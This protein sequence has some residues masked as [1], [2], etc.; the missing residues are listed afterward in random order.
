MVT[1]KLNLS[2]PSDLLTIP[3]SQ[4]LVEFPSLNAQEVG[5]LST[6]HFKA[7]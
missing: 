4:S 5:D 6:H 3:S 1:F 2:G 7:S